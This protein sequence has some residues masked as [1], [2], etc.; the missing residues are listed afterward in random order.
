MPAFLPRLARGSPA[1][2]LDRK[3]VISRSPSRRNHEGVASCAVAASVGMRSCGLRSH[4]RR[5]RAWRAGACD[6]VGTD[7]F[8]VHRPHSHSPLA[9][10]AAAALLLLVAVTAR[11]CEEHAL[12]QHRDANLIGGWRAS[13]AGRRCSD[14]RA[15]FGPAGLRRRMPIS[16]ALLK[17]AWLKRSARSCARPLLDSRATNP[18]TFPRAALARVGVTFRA[19]HS[20]SSPSQSTARGPRLIQSRR[21]DSPDEL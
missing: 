21:P 20:E 9:A 16:P 2:P 5:R 15:V 19:V 14:P 17:S 12:R 6:H 3:L 18:A 11:F 10:S 4:R 7:S 8:L 13:S 1:C